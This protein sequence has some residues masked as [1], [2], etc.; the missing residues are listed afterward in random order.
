MR[1]DVVTLFPTFFDGP[2]S[3]G[4]VGKTLAE[5]RAQVGCVDPRAFTQDRHRTVDDAP[6]G[7]GA[8][9]LMKPEPLAQAIRA[10]LARG[11]GGRVLLMSPQGRRPTQADLQTWAQLD[12]L[13]LVAGRYEGYDERIRALVDDEVSLGDFVLTGGEYAALTLID[14]V[15][16]LRPGTL[17]N[18]E[19][20]ETDSFS[21]GLL[22]HPHYTRP[23]EFEGQAVPEVLRSGDHARIATWRRAQALLR[24]RQRRPDLLSRVALTPA[25]REVLWQTP[26][27]AP[28]LGLAVRC[29][30]DPEAL[31]DLADLAA[32]YGL[33]RVWAVAGKDQ[34]T[35]MQAALQGAPQRRYS[36]PHLPKK[37]RRDIPAPL[38]RA[39]QSTI[40]VIEGFEPLAEDPEL[41]LVAGGSHLVVCPLHIEPQ[42][43]AQPRSDGRLWV[44]AVGPELLSAR[45]D[46][47][48][49]LVGA[50]G[51]IRVGT[52]S[53]GFTQMQ[54]AAIHLDRVLGER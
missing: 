26:P 17:G 42:A 11:Q 30:P 39:P 41:A 35:V 28:P 23:P 37:R 45:G 36:V 48:E 31:A 40:Q 47:L 9:M 3:T 21:E 38:V 25:D 52:R 16:R 22:E 49:G 7:G 12:H 32:S 29:R 33:S 43:M 5:G 46:P 27:P 44:L 18:T 15:L 4:L 53:A 54:R 6:Y 8:G 13:V 19:S 2:L 34:L 20:S 50:L 1:I 51:P 10:A 14:G 24:T